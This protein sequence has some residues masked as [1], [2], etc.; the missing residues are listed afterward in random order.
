MVGVFRSEVP[1]AREALPSPARPWERTGRVD[2]EHL[3]AWAYGSQ[4]VDRFERVGLHAIEAEAAGFEPRGYSSDGVGQLM[5]IEHLGCR[6]DAGAVTVADTC[7]PAAYAVAQELACVEHGGRVRYH[8]MSASRPK[9]WMPPEQFAR[10]AVWVKPWEKAQVEY[11][12][13]GRKGAY[14][15]VIL[16]WDRRREEWGRG[17]YREWWTALADLAWR[18][19]TRAL[20]FAVTGPAAP[21]APWYD[22]KR[23][24]P[25]SIALD[26]RGHP[27]RGSSESA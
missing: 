25:S 14:C 6:I 18:L 20:G 22:E 1:Q 4:M 7:H 23:A 2:V 13:P 26:P 16:L 8:A 27:P 24:E 12:G 3:A 17:Q 19:S 5:A 9:E 15:Q 11:Q 21:A 10:A